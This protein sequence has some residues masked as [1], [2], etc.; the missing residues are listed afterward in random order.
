MAGNY[1]D[2]YESPHEDG[3]FGG[4][5]EGIGG[6]GGSGPWGSAPG[7]GFGG[8]GGSS[9]LG[10]V[11]DA[12]GGA[13]GAVMENKGKIIIAAV[14]IVAAYFAYMYFIGDVMDVS[15]SVKDTEDGA[16]PNAA[17]KIYGSGNSLVA[18]GSAGSSMK[19]RKGEYS[20]EVSAGGYKKPGLVP[21]TVASNGSISLGELEKDIDIEL[22][23]DFPAE[24]AMGEQAT[25]TLKIKNGGNEGVE[26]ELVFSGAL[27]SKYMDIEYEKPVY[28]SPGST[29]LEL[30]I[31]VKSS[32]IKAG[33]GLK[34]TVRVNGLKE[35]LDVKYNLTEFSCSKVTTNPTTRVEFGKVA[36]GAVVNKPIE[37]TNQNDAEMKGA[38]FTLE[39]TTANENT[40]EAVQGWFEFQPSAEDVSVSG[41][42]KYSAQIVGKIPLDAKPE[43]KVLGKIHFAN[44]YC[45]KALDFSMVIG[46]TKVGLELQGL[47]DSYSVRKASATGEY[48]QD[49]VMLTL[50][51]T[52][53]ADLE[54]ISIEI[55]DYESTTNWLS[56]GTSEFDKIEAGA[57]VETLMK[58]GIPSSEDGT[59]APIYVLVVEYLN[60]LTGKR[61]ALRKMFYIKTE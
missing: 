54:D 19:L 27:E 32:G 23:W 2:K 3:G 59:Q 31:K 13:L 47:R 46:E 39:I 50:K 24:L 10:Q 26:V 38:A 49:P 34:G 55:T 30:N 18:Q 17:V 5:G 4:T 28:V 20:A 45:E 42:S 7:G 15:F 43:V 37:V 22:S 44:S 48:T 14:V 53:Q 8:D 11:Q 6:G 25:A 29:E 60:P 56:F 36:G 52:G 21:V 9:G 61:E 51:N 16:I 35:G 57:S 33:E 12:A 58:F 40:A 1:G 41:K